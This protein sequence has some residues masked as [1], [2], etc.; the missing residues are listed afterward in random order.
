MHDLLFNVFNGGEVLFCM[1]INFRITFLHVFFLTV[2][3]I[4]LCEF[5]NLLI[6][7]CGVLK[8]TQES[9]RQ[10]LKKKKQTNSFF[11]IEP[12]IKYLNFFFLVFYQIN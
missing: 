4:F 7:L 8:D 6:Q 12:T 9:F 5:M 10:F 2:V 1:L 11:L 3:I